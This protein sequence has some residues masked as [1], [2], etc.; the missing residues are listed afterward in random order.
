[1]LAVLAWGAMLAL[2][3]FLF[4]YDHEYQMI[5]LAPSPVRGLIVL[6]CVGVFLGGWALLLRNRNRVAKRDNGE[7]L[8]NTPGKPGR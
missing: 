6:S 2:G 5:T 1:M 8:S 4:G 3:A 7:T